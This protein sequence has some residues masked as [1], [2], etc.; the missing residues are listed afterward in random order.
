M[1]YFLNQA[2]TKSISALKPMG[3][4]FVF[5]CCKTMYIAWEYWPD[6]LE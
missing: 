1:I 3:V 2:A 4:I 5:R 6:T